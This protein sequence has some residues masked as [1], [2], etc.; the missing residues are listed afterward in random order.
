[1][2]APPSARSGL[3]TDTTTDTTRTDVVVG[4]AGDSMAYTPTDDPSQLVVQAFGSGHRTTFDPSDLPVVWGPAGD[5]FATHAG[6]E[7]SAQATNPQF[8]L[9]LFAAGTD[10]TS[11]SVS[12]YGNRVMARAVLQGGADIVSRPAPFIGSRSTVGDLD[13]GLDRYLPGPPTQGQ[14]PGVGVF[15]DNDGATYLAFA[16]TDPDTDQPRLFVDHQDGDPSDPTAYVAPV[17]TADVGARCD[18][19]APAFSPNRRMLAYVRAVGTGGSPCSAFEVRAVLSDAD[20]YYA[21]GN[22]D[23]LLWSSGAGAPTPSVLSWRPA[24][25]AASAERIS[26]DNRYEV[27]ANTAAGFWATGSADAVVLAGG[28]AYADALAGGPLASALGAPSLLTPSTSLH[29]ATAWAIDDVLTPGGTVYVLGGTNSVSTTVIRQVQAMGFSVKRIGG[30]SR[31]DV[32]VNVAK[33][34]DSLRG[35]PATAAFVASGKAFADALV[36]GPPATAYDAPVLL[37]N[38]GSLPSVTRTYLDSLGSDAALFAIGGAGAASISGDARTE[39]VGG[40]TRYDVAGNVADRFFAGWFLL[41]LADGRNWPDAVSGGTLMG[42][43]GQPILL[44]NGTSSLP[45]ATR[46]QILQTRE[47]I[48]TVFAFGGTASIPSKAL[49]RAASDAG[50]QTSLYGPD[51]P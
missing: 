10:A 41:A 39:V 42:Q 30:A 15:P 29:P 36:A 25:P 40:A 49:Q 45:A 11:V 34:L 47:S 32:A 3:F 2:S 50:A 43:Y 22:T 14:E 13:L 9:P 4:P 44:T 17:P 19:A 8:S 24:N 20:G 7:F 38:G 46:E 31:F 12:P 37:S 21:L 18:A 26:G 1:M 23:V 27:A 28:K 51:L 35:A 5:G 6:G 16:G 48:D 33:K